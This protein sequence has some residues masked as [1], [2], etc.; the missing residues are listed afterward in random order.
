MSRTCALDESAV[1]TLKMKSHAAVLGSRGQI[2]GG[3]ANV[4]AAD[5]N[6]VVI[7]K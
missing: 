4:S 2:V 7:M 1:A 6:D 3:T 5:L